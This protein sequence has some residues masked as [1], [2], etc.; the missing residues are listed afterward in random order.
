MQHN[1]Y[2]AASATQAFSGC[3]LYP[4][5]FLALLSDLQGPEEAEKLIGVWVVLKAFE[6]CTW[7]QKVFPNS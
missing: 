7:A 2:N 3:R 5:T 4:V 1:T 6:S